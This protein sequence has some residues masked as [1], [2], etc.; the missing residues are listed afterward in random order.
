MTYVERLTD[1]NGFDVVQIRARI[2]VAFD[3]NECVGGSSNSSVFVFESRR[4]LH[5]SF[6]IV[7]DLIGLQNSPQKKESAQKKGD[8]GL[9]IVYELGPERKRVLAC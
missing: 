9:C 2:G 8:T 5:W 7:L 1:Q 6:S 4:S 3:L